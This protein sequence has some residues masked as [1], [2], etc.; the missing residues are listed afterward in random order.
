MVCTA[1]AA[2][3][4]NV[5]I[6]TGQRFS[7]TDYYK[8]VEALETGLNLAR[9][10]KAGECIF[11]GKLFLD[12]FYWMRV[13]HSLSE[14]D[15]EGR[16]LNVT[17]VISETFADTF[18]HCY[19]F[20]KDVQKLAVLQNKSFLDDNDRY[21]SFLFNMLANAP[22][23][24]TE[25]EEL[26]KYNEVSDWINYSKSLGKIVAALIYYESAETGRLNPNSDLYSPYF[27][28]ENG[29][30][31]RKQDVIDQAA[32]LFEKNYM[33]KLAER[34]VFDTFNGPIQYVLNKSEEIL[35]LDNSPAK[36]RMITPIVMETYE[37]NF[38]IDSL[39]Q[40]TFGF[41]DGALN[42]LPQGGFLQ[43]CGIEN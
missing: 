33:S 28:D 13:N 25:S 34:G 2:V 15:W 36:V 39:F 31:L 6:I 8:I 23:L 21:T 32:V 41:L 1:D 9:Y 5:D 22:V 18:Y 35:P 40:M 3:D 26:I 17:R 37:Y 12:D 29:I 14:N 7:Q 11:N 16:F 24:Y 10:P 38:T 19:E 30:L 20:M 4:L 27:E 42:T 43:Q